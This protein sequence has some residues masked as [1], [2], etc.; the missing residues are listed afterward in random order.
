MVGES[1]ARPR[2]GALQERTK[3]SAGEV[4]LDAEFV[5]QGLRLE[6][7]APGR[8]GFAVLHGPMLGDLDRRVC[9]RDPEIDARHDFV[10]FSIQ[11]VVAEPTNV[12]VVRQ[13]PQYLSTN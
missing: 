5:E 13:A 4:M 1:P 9:T 11:Y 2:A 6:V 3:R 7:S 10:V 12:E 8:G